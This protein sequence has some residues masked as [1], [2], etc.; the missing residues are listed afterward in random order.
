[1]TQ[2]KP[3]RG[4]QPNMI[5]PLQRGCT[6]LWLFNEGTGNKV[7][8]YSG[9]KNTCTLTNCTWGNGGAYYNGTSGYGMVPIGPG[10]DAG[11]NSF[12]VYCKFY[13][14]PG[15]TNYDM[16][17][18]KGASTQSTSGYSL[19]LGTG[20]WAGYI[21]DGVNLFS[22]I[23]CNE[24]ANQN[25]SICMVVNRKTQKLVGY[26]NGIL[27]TG[28][29]TNI[30]TCGSISNSNLNLRIGKASSYFFNGY[31]Q[32]VRIYQRDLSPIEIAWLAREPYAGFGEDN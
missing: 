28:A 14:L 3:F 6:G 10:L 20:V 5:H 31:I 7:W 12:T 17:I 2:L 32:Q 24:F 9:N 16:P 22:T 29:G 23:F 11:L 19:Q 26:V 27:T 30:S 13:A 15:V 1:M 21:S 8:D 25:V 18:Y 4:M